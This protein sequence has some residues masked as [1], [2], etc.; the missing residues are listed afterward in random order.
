MYNDLERE[1]D[2]IDLF[3]Y[4]LSHWKSFVAVILAAL[5][6]SGGAFLVFGPKGGTE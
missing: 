1:I 6:I 4:W 3:F 2:L 5:L